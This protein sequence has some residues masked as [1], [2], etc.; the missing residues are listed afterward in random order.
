MNKRM[1]GLKIELM[2]NDGTPVYQIKM[3]FASY[4]KMVVSFIDDV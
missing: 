4:F 2:T 3:P 1:K